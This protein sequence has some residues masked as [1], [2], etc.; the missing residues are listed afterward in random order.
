MSLRALGVK[1]GKHK[2]AHGAQH[3]PRAGLLL[4]NS[5]HV[6]RYNTSTRRLTPAMF[7]DVVKEVAAFLNHIARPDSD[8]A[9][10][11]HRDASSAK[12]FY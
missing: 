6:S 4:A 12:K 8:L 10:L 11:D 3:H 7:E 1:P 5:Y 2:F 9:S